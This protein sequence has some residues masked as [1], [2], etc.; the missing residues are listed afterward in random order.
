MNTLSTGW[1]VVCVGGVGW[2]GVGSNNWGLMNIVGT[3]EFMSA[4]SVFE[5]SQSVSGLTFSSGNKFGLVAVTI[6]A[7][8]VSISWVLCFH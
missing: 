8:S 2:E 1:Q 4:V 3:Y 7:S 6:R 5:T